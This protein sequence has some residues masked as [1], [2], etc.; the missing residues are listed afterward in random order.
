MDKCRTTTATRFP[1][2]AWSPTGT[3]P[4]DGTAISDS[5]GNYFLAM[6]AGGGFIEVQNTG[7]APADNYL[8]TGTPFFVSNGQAQQTN[9]IGTIP[10]AR[11]RSLVT[12]D[13]GAPVTNVFCFANSLAGTSEGN[14][15]NN[16]WLDMPV[17]AGTWNL[18]IGSTNVI[19]PVVPPFTITDGVNFTNNIV[20]RTITGHI[21]G[22]V[23]NATN[24]GLPNINV[25]VT[26]SVG[27][28]N[29]V[30]PTVTDANGAYSV[31]VFNGTWNVSLG[32]QGL[33][34]AGYEP[35]NP[36]NVPVPPANAVADSFR[37]DPRAAN[38]DHQPAGVG[39]GGFLFHRT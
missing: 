7:D 26:N 21:S 38:P 13:T 35:V 17:F 12:D 4:Y 39:A 28:T 10:T 2:W 24:A 22:H 32:P 15:G 36:L 23:H 9:V 30:L 3:G 1:G 31:A 14:T 37:S 25:T 18:Y 8:W 33:E 16:G 5:N 27:S 20:A 11:F 29:F 34:A 6:D 19:F